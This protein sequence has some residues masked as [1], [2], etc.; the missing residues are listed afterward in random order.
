[1]GWMNDILRYT[2]TNYF[3]RK[4]HH[5]LINFSL[6]YAFNENFILPLS[7]DEVVHRKKSLINKMYGDYWQKFAGLRALYSFMI[8]HPGK[9]LLFMGGEF[10]Q[11]V[12]WRDYSSL[13]WNLFEYDMHRKLNNFIREL[14]HLY[15]NERSL[16]EIDYDWEGFEWVDSDDSFHSIVSFIRRGR[17]PEEY[18]IFV[19]NFTPVV[20][21]VNRIGVP[22]NYEYK[23]LLNSDSEAYGGSGIVNP[24]TIEA[25]KIACSNQP[26]SIVLKVPPLGGIFLKPVKQMKMGGYH[27]KEGMY[28]PYT[29]RGAG[30]QVGEPNKVPCKASGSIRREV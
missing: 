19:C 1:M 5:R 8:A 26:Y 9:K 18:L 2:G 6:M 17:K 24:G 30:K 7:H 16:F 11:F 25:E 22:F 28:S 15:R 4:H 3:F 13:D 20:H 21:G 29:G 27:E 12:E 23:E 10:G 14:N